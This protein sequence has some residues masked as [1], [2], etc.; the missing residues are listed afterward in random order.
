VDCKAVRVGPQGLP[1]ELTEPV[2]TRAV[3]VFAHG[4]GSGHRSPRNRQV[5]TV[6]QRHRLSTLL[7]DLLTEDEAQDRRHVFDITLLT[8]RLVEAIAWVG[9]PR[10]PLG[11]FGA[12]TG[13]AA[14]LQAAA[15]RPAA[16]GA[17]VLRGGR[18]D[19]APDIA[20]VHAPTLLVVG[21]ADGEV[22]RMNRQ[23]AQ[24]LQCRK[25]LEV[26][27]GATHLF[28]QPGALDA[29]ALLAA[30]WFNTH[31]AGDGMA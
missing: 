6:L 5:A 12:S 14:A 20:R 16:V 9:A 15:A 25:R 19:L 31:L 8:Q 21:G 26:V 10:R 24:A 17:L 4:S 13:A 29:V 2:D 28:E 27:P 7:F 18:P 3:V 23:A 11:L 22:L 30:H 1:G